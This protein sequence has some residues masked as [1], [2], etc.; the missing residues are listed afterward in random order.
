MKK[1]SRRGKFSGRK[2]P[3]AK[4]SANRSNH[5]P[6][7]SPT[8]FPIVGVGASAGGLEAF[9]ELL[10]HLPL[11]SGMGFVLVQ[12]LD[13]QHESALT[14]LLKR[15]TSMPVEDVTNNLRVE[16]NHIYVI[17]RNTRLG[18]ARG[19]LKLQPRPQNRGA[20]HPIDAFFEALAQDQREC[21]IGVILSGAATDGTLGLEAIKAEGG[22]TFAQDDSARYDSMPRNAAAAGC[23]DFVLNPE[24]IAKELARIAKHPYVVN[25]SDQSP[26]LQVKAEREGDQR[27][28]PEVPLASGGRGSP[29]TGAK[30]APA[31]AKA[32]RDQP[33]TG[34]DDEFK[35]IL[36]L[37]R[38]HCGVDFSLY[39]SATIQRRITRRIVLSKCDA[40]EDYAK[41]LKGNGKELDALY[42]D[43]LINVTSF[44]RNPESFEVLQREVFPILLQKSSDDEPFRIWVLGC[45]TGQEAYSIA[46]AFQEVQDKF[47]RA[48]KLQVF[49][50]DLN[51]ALL[52]KARHG[53]YTKHLAQDLSPERLRRFFIEE[54]GGYRIIKSL[55]EAV[56]FARQNL[57]SDPPFSRMHLISCRNVLIYLEP[58]LQ[59][60]A[61]PT[62]HYALKPDGFLFLGSSESISGFDDL[63]EPVDRKH[64]IYSRKTVLTPAFH[65][66]IKKESGEAVRVIPPAAARPVDSGRPDPPRGQPEDLRGDLNAQREADRLMVNQF[67]P[68]GVLINAKLQILQFRGPTSAWL[69]PPSGKASFDV[70]KMARE[71]L[72]LPLRAAINKAK[73]ENKTVRREKVRVQQN[74]QTRTVNVEVV[75]LKNL[76]E[77]CFLILFEDKDGGHVKAASVSELQQAKRISGVR[78]R[79]ATERAEG[80]NAARSRR[81]TELERELAEARDY[82]QSIE[83]QHEASDEE[84]QAANEEVQSSNEELQSINEELET[85]KEELESSNEE[86][87]TVNEEMGHRNAEL[88]RLNSDLLNLQTSTTLGILLLSRD[89]TI[90]RF[91]VQAEKQ[92]N[93]IAADAGRPIRSIRHNFDLTGLEEFLSEVIANVRERELEVRDKAGRWYSLRARPY[94]TVDNKVDGAV[95]VVVD[96]DALK[97]AEQR[98]TQARLHA[99]AVVEDAPPLLILDENLRVISSNQSFYQQFKVSPDQ[100]E[101][102]LVYELGNGQWNIP[103]LRTFLEDVLPRNSFFKDFEIVHEFETIGRRTMLLSGHRLD[104]LR[105]ILLFINDITE[106]VESQ[107]EVRASELRYRTLFESAKDGILILDPETRK[108][109]QANPFVSEMLGYARKE[110]IGKELWQLGLWK[111]QEESRAAFR[112]LQ[113]K[114]F[115]RYDDLP[116]KTKDGRAIQVEFVSNLYHEDKKT[117][118]QCNIRD[119]SAQVQ[120]RE[121]IAADLEA[122]TRLHQAGTY[123]AQPGAEYCNCIAKLLDAAIALTGASKGNIQLLDAATGTLTIAT[124]RGFEEPFLEFFANVRAGESSAGGRAVHSGERVIVEDV[125]QSAIFAGQPSL[126]ILLEAG[127]RAVQSTPLMN[128]AARLL[129]MIST[130]F[131][132]PRRFT[133][134]ELRLMDLLARQA[135]DYL[136][137]KHGEDAVRQAQAQLADRAGQ[138]EQAVVERTAELTATNQQLETFVYS[139]AHDLRAPLR[140]MQGYSALLVEEA[141]AALSETGRDFAKRID[142]S[143]RLMDAL[144]ID[145]LA[146]SRISQQRLELT[147]VSLETLVASVLLRLQT[148]IQEKN[149]RV[150]SAGPWSFVLAH[151]TTLAQVLVN[152]VCN[153]LKFAVQDVPPLIRL[154]AE[155]RDCFVRVWVEDNGIGIEPGHQAQ[156]FRL[157]IRLHGEKYSGTGIGLAIVQKGIERM[158]GRVGVEST[159]GHGSRFWFE[160]KKAST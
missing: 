63:F 73:K 141:G 65:L 89:L 29:R 154:S 28:G 39:K 99:Q 45:S 94:L 14:K 112:E 109:T 147:L 52:E 156:I 68:P 17:P 20:H 37:V 18:I 123:C 153:A 11:D 114:S 86:L 91:S 55:R 101:N 124:Q 3:T 132:A 42:S 137:R 136:E 59:K 78:D 131:D 108:V 43:C 13:P 66:P 118:I 58:S 9:T 21:A 146:F 34:K 130:H 36:L 85:A 106:R 95:L 143:A 50:T 75:P 151:E 98:A 127:V 103:K 60:R 19:V 56:I 8:R 26:A 149:A 90:R 15:A 158:G 79:H 135:A 57:I 120:A 49:A 142:R 88:S 38:N 46:M 107:E 40:V 71:G 12:H 102:I 84:L 44:F 74:G 119:I 110:F 126:N 6:T 53:L 32:A 10:K 139:I 24:H 113:E 133:E 97:G 157:F 87:T 27:E 82:L 54:D 152:L 92:F 150:E 35:Q 116:L 41:F 47:P 160:L 121:T 117:V 145:L 2:K 80:N 16:P 70:L 105:Q 125:T 77:R 140:S 33:L 144:L 31:Q 48:R 5:R 111:N 7:D 134:R 128:S 22:I 4:R 104:H 1:P 96:I 148:E 51:E 138:L 62:F 159:P 69:E 93:L 76:R 64:K 30:Q 83:E 100:T 67:A 23:V 115:V 61:L 72:M 25:A 129:G 81:A 155:E 122:V